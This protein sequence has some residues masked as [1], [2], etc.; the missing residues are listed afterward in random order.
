MERRKV[1]MTKRV[2][3]TPLRMH[4]RNNRR[5]R[6]V[7]TRLPRWTTLPKAIQASKEK[8]MI[9][10]SIIKVV[11]MDQTARQKRITRR[12]RLRNRNMVQFLIRIRQQIRAKTQVQLTR[13]TK[14]PRQ[15]TA[16]PK[17]RTKRTQLTTWRSKSNSSSPTSRHN[18]SPK[19][20]QVN[21][22]TKTRSSNRTKPW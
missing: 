13:Q 12:I 21:P 1:K 15:K 14:M 5:T 16:N 11:S 19:L 4:Q 22:M 18:N 10:R 17:S 6:T 3:L 9:R 20:T 7:I 2:L 8:R